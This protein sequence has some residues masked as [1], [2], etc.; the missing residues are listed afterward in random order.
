MASRAEE[1]DFDSVWTTE[2]LLVPRAQRPY[3][4]GDG[5]IPEVYKTTLDALDSLA[6]VAGQTSRI[7]LG[8]SVL[9][10]PWYNPPLLVRR[11]TTIDVL[12][13]GRLNVG[14]GIG[15]SPE[16]YKA[17]GSDGTSAASASRKHSER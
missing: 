11:L 15:W 4:V 7:R 6:F 8:V 1:L 3:P 9:N 14:F 13:E 2:R 17:V 12:S 16:E 5:R 10:L